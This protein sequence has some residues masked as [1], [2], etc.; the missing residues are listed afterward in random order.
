MYVHVP[1]HTAHANTHADKPTRSPTPTPTP[2]TVQVEY[3]IDFSGVPVGVNANIY[4]ISPT[5]I[6]GGFAQS[7]YCDG[8]GS[9]PW[10]VEV[11]WIESNGNCG[12]ATTLHT[13]PGTGN[14]GCTAWGC[15]SN[16][17]YG[18]KA[19]FHMREEFGSDGTWT[20]KRD[21][22]TISP[23]SLSPVPGGVD[24]STLKGAY[25]SHGAVVYS[26][27]WVGWVPVDDCGGGGNLASAHFSVRN[28]RIYGAVVQGPT[29]QPC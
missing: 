15:R 4:S 23:S 20:T 18:G 25:E 1:A 27:Q 2:A 9:A 21:G 16:Y 6:G 13:K 11:D 3:D 17:H 26:S 7:D 19:S 22:Q 5:N 10:C 8:A 24:W 14:D 12:G 29:P 28:L